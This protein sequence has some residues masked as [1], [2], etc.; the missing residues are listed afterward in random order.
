MMIECETMGG[1]AKV[2]EALG[3]F[4]G[5]TNVPKLDA[6]AVEEF[7]ARRRAF[8]W[9][10]MGTTDLPVGRLL[11]A[12]RATPGLLA[13]RTGHLGNWGDIAASRAG[14]LDYNRVICGPRVLGY[15]LVYD[16]NQTEDDTGR[17][18]D[19]I[20]LPGSLVDGHRR[21]AL[22]LFTWDGAG[23]AER[24]RDRPLFCPL[25]LTPVGGAL[26]PLSR[27]H[28]QND[29]GLGVFR[30]AYG[31]TF[32][33]W[34]ADLVRAILHELLDWARMRPDP[35]RAIGDVMDRVVTLDGAVR[36]A[37]V[38]PDGRGFLAGDTRYA[39][40]T[41][42]VDAAM[43]PLL[44]ADEPDAFFAR[45]GEL[46]AE[47]PLLSVLTVGLLYALL[48]A[49]YPGVAIDRDA[50]T[51]PINPH[52]HW[53]ALGMA[54]YPPRRRGYF[55]EKVKQARDLCRVI[56]DHFEEIDPVLFVLL[57][58]SIFALWPAPG[59]PRDAALVENLI[60]RIHDA[61]DPLI[62]KPNLMMPAVDREVA[63]WLA[64]ARSELSPYF[65]GRF[66][67]R[68]SVCNQA[69][70]PEPGEPIEPGGF[71][72]LTIGQ[73]SMAVGALLEFAPG[74]GGRA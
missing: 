14:L 23:F 4:E 24:P 28:R 43:L 1:P 2:V 68:R 69:P 26:A 55:R 10:N 49:H 60:R 16:L 6:R 8:D 62:G 18:G 11:A 5:I 53:G 36:R 34:R 57:P 56:V 21:T 44:A 37:A 22:R 7:A 30:F 9:V 70:L 3:L 40:T 48:G 67:D 38:V 64:A 35:P 45:I 58:A 15:P 25:V 51:R 63:A 19:S 50:M 13:P 74:A 17:D 31:S 71:S 39:D 33:R 32:L 47:L 29:A 27:I 12:L 20:Y 73:A 59:E 61:T 42:L 54:G 65:L 41:A 46:P 72:D 52:V 66:T